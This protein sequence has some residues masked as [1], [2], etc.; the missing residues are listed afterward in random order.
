M[1]CTL[2][3]S[4]ENLFRINKGKNPLF[5]IS[6]SVITTKHKYLPKHLN[7]QQKINQSYKYES[8]MFAE[9]VLSETDRTNYHFNQL[10]NYPDWGMYPINALPSLHLIE[11]A[12]CH[13]VRKNRIHSKLMSLLLFNS[14]NSFNYSNESLPDRFTSIPDQIFQFSIAFLFIFIP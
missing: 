14:R 9:P 12:N 7:F 1:T 13:Y 4:N 3:V 2:P 8:C 11:A 10:L 5:Y 6:Y